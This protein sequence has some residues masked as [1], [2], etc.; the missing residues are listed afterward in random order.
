ML[1]TD[2]SSFIDYHHSGHTPTFEQLD[3]LPDNLA[4]T[5]YMQNAYAME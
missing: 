5:R 1:K 2:L 3:L 4:Y